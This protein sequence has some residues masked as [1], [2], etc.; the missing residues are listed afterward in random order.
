MTL[1]LLLAAGCATRPEFK[2]GEFP[3]ESLT[4]GGVKREYRLYAPVSANTGRP[5]SL[6]VAFH[7]MWVDS[8]DVMPRYSKLNETAERHGFIIAYPNAL[9][10]VWGLWPSRTDADIAFFDALLARLSTDYRIDRQ[11]IYVLGMSNGGYFAHLLAR[12][13]STVIA[14]A[15][16]HSAAL[17]LQTLGGINAK[18]KFPVL[19]AHGSE[20]AIFGTWIARDNVERYRREGHEVEYIEVPRLGHFWA[21]EV[22]IN[23]RIWRFFAAHP[24]AL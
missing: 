24:R 12:E 10:G 14:A 19:I 1:A 7:G 20:D 5:A 16:G 3:N 4:V 15:A 22:D 9:G 17:G 8:K 13:R 6:V 21:S 11:R 23:E 18:R 2:T